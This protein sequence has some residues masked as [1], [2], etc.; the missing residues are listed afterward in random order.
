LDIIR[1]AELICKLDLSSEQEGML[2]RLEEEQLGMY[3]L[4][5]N[6]FEQY[7]FF[8]SIVKLFLN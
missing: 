1:F 2:K 6:G 5:N 3:P 7:T 8:Q 4:R